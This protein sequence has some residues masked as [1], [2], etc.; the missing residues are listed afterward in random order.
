MGYGIRM[1]RRGWLE[2]GDVVNT[3]SAGEFAQA[4]GSK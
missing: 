2:P 4:I 1:A 3:L